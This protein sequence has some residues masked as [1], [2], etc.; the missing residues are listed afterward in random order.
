M[1]LTMGRSFQTTPYVEQITPLG[2]MAQPEEIASAALFLA[3]DDARYVNGVEL[4]VD[5][6][7][8][9]I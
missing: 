8:S 7:L 4:M 6:G 1:T 3:S 9:Q 2:Y 5:G